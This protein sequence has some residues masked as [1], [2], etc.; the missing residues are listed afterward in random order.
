MRR[1][2][3]AGAAA[4]ALAAP[5]FAVTGGAV[6]G[7][8]HPAVG[9]LLADTG[10]GPQPDCSGSL[11][12]STV[13]VTAAHCVAGLASNRVWV[14]FDTQYV[15]GSSSLLSGAATS[16][17]LYGAVKGDSHDLAVVVLDAPVVGVQPFAL[18]PAGA[19]ES[20]DVKS[21]SFTN[22]GYG[23]VDKSTAFD[24]YRRVS[25]SSFTTLKPTELQLS[26]KQGGVCFGD[27]G[28]PRL[29]GNVE[30]AITS[31]GNVNCT[32]QSTSYRLDTASARAF[33]SGFVA[34]P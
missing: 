32:G 29:L 11:V 6:D 2:V 15:A 28:G 26:D 16:D 30:V 21:Q 1:I 9:L 13:L 33:L 18:P 34:I 4:L 3:I 7:T 5:A 17:P 31:T 27:S 8:A 23:L 22:V 10:S 19:L 24:G 14:S 20:P 12:S 25:T